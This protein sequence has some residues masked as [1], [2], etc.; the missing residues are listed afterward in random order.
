MTVITAKWTLEQYH[1]MIDAGIL[2][3]ASRSSH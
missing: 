1:Q 2:A 3:R